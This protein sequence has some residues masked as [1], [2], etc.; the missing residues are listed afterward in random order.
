MC[1][2]VATRHLQ[3]HIVMTC[4]A[5]WLGA[6]YCDQGNLDQAVTSGRFSTDLEA[7]YMCAPPIVC[8]MYPVKHG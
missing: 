5:A 2:N 4:K 7:V 6:E 1:C 3:D 8:L